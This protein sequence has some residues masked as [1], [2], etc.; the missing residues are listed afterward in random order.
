M[1]KEE[2]ESVEKA[3]SGTY[4]QVKLKVDGREVT[5]LRALVSKNRMG[6]G[7]YVDGSLKGEWCGLGGEHPE[8]RY[9]R[10]VSKF[11]WTD[12]QRRD[13]KKL[14]KKLLKEMGWDPDK[15]YHYFDPI[16]SNSTQ[17]RRHYQKTFQSIELQE[18]IGC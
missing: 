4:G 3:L 18:V 11:A 1:T 10:P 8:S 9:L 12:K 16:W 7:T 13:M 17:I 14:G 15:K 6:I 5:F 2:W